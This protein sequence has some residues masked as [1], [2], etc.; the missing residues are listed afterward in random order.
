MSKRRTKE[1]AP[2][3]LER[4]KAVLVSGFSKGMFSAP[5]KSDMLVRAA[6]LR[7]ISDAIDILREEI[8]SMS[9]EGKSTKPSE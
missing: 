6:Y 3:A 2:S 7:G 8:D 9:I 1:A 5:Q 4:L